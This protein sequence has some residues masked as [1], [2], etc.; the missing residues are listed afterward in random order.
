MTTF[1]H[2][3]ILLRQFED[4]VLE[5]FAQPLSA[6]TAEQDNGEYGAHTFYLAFSIIRFRTAKTTPTKIG[7]FVAI[8][9]RNEEG[10]NVPFDFDDE[11]DYYIIATN[12]DKNLG[13]FVFSK[14]VL[15]T[16][17]IISNGK[18]GGKRGIRVYP[19]WDKT[20]NKQAQKTQA[21]QTKYFFEISQ[22]PYRFNELLHNRLI[23]NNSAE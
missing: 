9:K 12:R 17:G 10:A 22:E 13:F 5:H 19:T 11:F 8:W 3:N 21:W 16:N 23:S 15:M 18:I 20:T 7:Q 2:S 4:F 14:S 1:Y 6:V